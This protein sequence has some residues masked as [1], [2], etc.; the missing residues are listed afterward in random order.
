[1]LCASSLEPGT[2]KRTPCAKMMVRIF[3]EE[4][5]NDYFNC[6]G[7]RPICSERCS[8]SCRQRRDTKRLSAR[9]GDE[10]DDVWRSPIVAWA[11]DRKFVELGRFE[12]ADGRPPC[13][14]PR[15][16]DSKPGCVAYA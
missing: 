12:T 1:M 15:G 8:R 13:Q 5:R 3:K 4:I 11:V 10:V 6:L 7:R 2:N 9:R 14:R 16:P